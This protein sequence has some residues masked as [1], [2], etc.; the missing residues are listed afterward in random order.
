MF[1]EKDLP[2]ADLG[3]VSREFFHDFTVHSSG[4]LAN[5]KDG[6]L[7]RDLSTAL[8]SLPDDMSG[9]SSGNDPSALIFPR[10]NPSVGE[11]LPL[12]MTAAKMDPGGPKWEQLSDYY[13]LA[14]DNSNL[15]SNATINLR[16][17]TNE[18]V[19]F[20][21]VITRSNFFVQGFAERN[22]AREASGNWCDNTDPGTLPG[23]DWEDWT[24]SD[25]DWYRARGYRYSLGMFPLVTLWNPYDRDMV[26]GDLGLEFELP[27][28]DIVDGPGSTTSVAAV[29]QYTSKWNGSPSSAV[30][31]WTVKFVIQGVTLKAGEAVN[32]SP[33]TNATYNA[34]TPTDNLLVARASAPFVNGFFTPAVTSTSNAVFWDNPAQLAINSASWS[35][36]RLSLN[37]SGGKGSLWRQLVMLYSSAD[38]GTNNQFIPGN[39]IKTIEIHGTG[40]FRNG[41]QQPRVILTNRVMG[42]GP[43]GDYDLHIDSSGVASSNPNYQDPFGIIKIYDASTNSYITQV[44]AYGPGTSY[45]SD[46]V[47]PQGDSLQN[48]KLGSTDY[49]A[50]NELCGN[51]L[52]GCNPWGAVGAMRFPNVPIRTWAN[53]GSESEIHL[54]SN[55]NPTAPVIHKEP[56]IS[57]DQANASMAE[58]N[59]YSKGHIKPWENAL[60]ADYYDDHVAAGT[61]ELQARVGFSN[62]QGDGG[63]ERMV[64]FEVPGNIPLSIGQLAHT[65]LMNFDVFSVGSTLPAIGN[66]IAGNGNKWNSHTLQT[67]ATPTY[68]IGNSLASPL[69]PLA[70]TEEWFSSVRK[71]WVSV[72]AAHYDYSYKLN[73]ALWD[74]YFFSGITDANPTFPLPNSRLSPSNSI[75]SNLDFTTENRAAANLLLDGAFNINSTSVAAWESV[76]GAMRDIETLGYSLDPTLR[77]NFARFNEPH[78]GVATIGESVPQLSSKDELVAGYRNLTDAQIA[79]LASKIV[80]EIRLRSATPNQ[81]GDK[82]PFLSLSEFINRSPTSN[83]QAFALRGALQSAIDKANLN[84]LESEDTGLWAESAEYP[85]YYDSGDTPIIDRPKA[86]G[87][88]GAFMQSDLLAK[89]GSFIQARSDTFTIRSFGSSQEQFGSSDGSRAYYEMVV[90][91]TPSYVDPSDLDYVNDYEIPIQLT[92]TN[93]KFGRKYEIK[94]QRWVAAD[95]I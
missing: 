95:E 11:N 78:M 28:I 9:G 66:C 6:G 76:L 89:I 41:W 5:A 49:I 45:F 34:S 1:L 31:R 65:N 82:Y 90:Q 8:L 60:E 74:G 83:N 39:R 50:G 75:S 44:K 22:P 85:L 20:T 81:N 48:I 92:D 7:K 3:N 94:S 27:K 15:P 26:L 33:P 80:D 21:P 68:A 51:G 63:S 62:K 93:E 43:S 18:Q 10:A 2:G 19:G 16:K 77:H 69:L 55:M 57:W 58:S 46:F 72:P 24:N 32:F 79:S 86:D 25:S 13:K 29:G 91:R 53:T 61:G 88:P 12:N 84:G 37:V 73:D 35:K 30:K 87:M 59:V 4:V 52:T 36:S 47:G 14:Y 54:F 23:S 56:N 17:P 42:E 40:V 38:T 64:L 67:Y 70:S 71:P